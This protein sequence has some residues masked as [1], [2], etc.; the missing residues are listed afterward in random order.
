MDIS[1]CIDIGV[2]RDIDQSWQ[3][4]PIQ[5]S[6]LQFSGAEPLAAGMTAVFTLSHRFETDTG[7]NELSNKPL[8]HGESTLGLKGAFGSILFGRRMDAMYSNDWSFDPWNYF[9]RI[10]SPGW[11]L[12]HRNY[13][14]DPKGNNLTPEYGRLNN[15][16]FYDSP[17]LGGLTVHLSGSPELSAGDRN[18]PLTSAVQYRSGVF[19]GMVS[20]GKN[21]ADH[22]ANFVGL[23]A[24]FAQFSVMGAYDVSKADSSTAKAVTLGALYTSGTVTWKA[25]VGQVKVDGIQAE[26]MAGL[27]ATYRLSGRTSVYADLAHKRYPARSASTYGVGL[28]HRF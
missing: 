25:G 4:G 12:W 15:G 10:A 13:A 23:R 19:S 5:R 26:R 21:S 3:T 1:G 24:T 17:D 6:H 22:T 2:Y 27:G 14:S 9:D 7:G 18:H 20:R 11:D 28:N 16:I 8:W